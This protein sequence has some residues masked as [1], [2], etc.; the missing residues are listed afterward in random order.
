MHR[1]AALWSPFNKRLILAGV[2]VAANDGQ[3]F[4]IATGSKQ[5][6]ALAAAWAPVFT[7]K[8]VASE[9]RDEYLSAWAHPVNLAECAQPGL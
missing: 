5:V 9:G 2:R 4:S 6:E 8:Q 3:Q 1:I 7:A